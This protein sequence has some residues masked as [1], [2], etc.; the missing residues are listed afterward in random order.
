MINKQGE[1][2]NAK[3]TRLIKYLILMIN[4]LRLQKYQKKESTY[5]IS[6]IND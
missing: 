4:E 2:K 6:H 3:I 1:L 5:K